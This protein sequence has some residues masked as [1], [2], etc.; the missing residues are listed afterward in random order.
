MII[1]KQQEPKKTTVNLSRDTDTFEALKKD[2]QDKKASLNAAING[3]LTKYVNF[4]KR[5]EEY[6]SAVIVSTQFAVFIELMDEEKTAEIM[7][8]DGTATMIAYFQHNNIPITLDSIIDIAFATVSIASG[9]CTKFSQHRDEEGYRCL[10]FD[11]RYGI[12]WSRIVSKVFSY[13]LKATCNVDTS[14]NV[15]PQTI[16]LRILQR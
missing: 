13:L 3:I 1:A 8:R 6:G 11:H 14:V 12:K 5:A 15:L 10:V 7:S 4:Y 2:A 9:V 16:S